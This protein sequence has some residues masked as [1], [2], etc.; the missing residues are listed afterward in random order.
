MSTDDGLPEVTLKRNRANFGT[1]SWQGQAPQ[2]DQL[3][4]PGEIR[5]QRFFDGWAL[6]APGKAT[7]DTLLH[8][9]EDG[10]LDGILNT[11]PYGARENDGRKLDDP[12]EVCLTIRPDHDMD[13]IR[14]LMDEA[15]RRWGVTIGFS[16][17]VRLAIGDSTAHTTVGALTDGN[18]RQARLPKL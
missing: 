7:I 8:Y 5:Y 15:Q 16:S 11:Y 2:Y 18:R 13:V 3:G 1:Y 6:T 14:P 12:G 9:D 10:N 4:E 17:G